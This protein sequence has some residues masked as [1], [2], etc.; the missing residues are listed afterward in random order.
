MQPLTKHADYDK[1]MYLWKILFIS[2]EFS[3]ELTSSGMNV[4]NMQL[5]LMDF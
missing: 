3:I 1:H 2:L 5:F 4:Q